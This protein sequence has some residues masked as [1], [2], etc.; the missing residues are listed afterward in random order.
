MEETPGF[1]FPNPFIDP[2][3]TALARMTGLIPLEE[4]NVSVLTEIE[5]EGD[6]ISDSSFESS[7]D[8]ED[9]IPD[10]IK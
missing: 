7:S 3:L 1:Q 5:E 8:S 6:L 2:A 4:D 10:I 9:E